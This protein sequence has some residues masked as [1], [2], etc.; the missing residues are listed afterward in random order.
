MKKII[1]FGCVI[2]S[3]KALDVISTNE[4]LSIE[5]IITKKNTN[6]KISDYSCLESYVKNSSTKLIYINDILEDDMVKI[7]RDLSPDYIFCIGWPFIISEKILSI[8]K[9]CSIGFHPTELPKNRGHH[10]ITWAIALGLDRTASTFFKM[11]GT[12]D[13]GEIINQKI[14]KINEDDTSNSLYK[15]II[16]IMQL[17]IDEIID[18]ILNDSV[19][20]TE[21]NDSLSNKWRKRNYE[22]GR[23][24]FRMSSKS[25][26]NLVKSLSRPYPGAHINWDQN[27]VKVW[28][29]RHIN[30]TNKNIE[31]GKVLDIKNNII[32]VK[33]GED[34]V[35][36]I[37]HE[38]EILPNVGDYL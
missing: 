24:D 26:C 23:I 28:K 16:S 3:K 25:V 9:E 8:P 29:V 10:P 1:F 30:N 13:S 27:E 34:A 37:E 22:D 31:P 2:S 17:Q 7:I 35:E 4:N 12:V 6:N 15:K 33:C 32:L 18:D 36:F 38:F 21:Q 19:E 5:A 14:I 11:K 20:F